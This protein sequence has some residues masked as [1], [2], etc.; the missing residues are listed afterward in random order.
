MQNPI[1]VIDS[2]CGGLHILAK[3]ARLLPHQNFV[4]IAD[5]FNAPFG[6]KSHSKLLKIAKNLVELAIEKYNPHIIV[7]A[8]NTLTVNAIKKMRKIFPKINFVGV[9]PA[10]KQAQIYGGNTIIFATPSTQRYF[11]KLK[12]KVRFQLRSEYRNQNLKYV[13]SGKIFR[14]SSPNLATQ[15]DN[16][17]QNL[18]AL[19]PTIKTIFAKPK[20]AGCQNLVLGCTHYLAIKAQIEKVLPQIKMFDVAMPVAKQ[21]QKFAPNKTQGKQKIIFI[22]TDGNNKTKQKF[23][24]YFKKIK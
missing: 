18:D 8:C 11:A 10:L 1:V 6:K 2:G 14:V 16:N 15:I 23:Q 17:L 7:F 22:T 12:M 13:P 5:T 20:F 3:C 4:Y 19:I 24:K 21:V 9:E